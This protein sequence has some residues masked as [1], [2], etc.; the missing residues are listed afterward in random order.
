MYDPMETWASKKIL[1]ELLGELGPTPKFGP[2][3]GWAVHFTINENFV[4]ATGRDFLGSRDIDVFLDCRGNFPLQ[5]ARAI[6]KI[7]F[8]PGEY[9]FRY[10]LILERDSMRK[11]S[12][13]EAGRKHSFELIYVF[14]DV[15]GNGESDAVGVW[16]NEIVAKMIKRKA[17]RPMT[18][19]GLKVFVPEEDFLLLL[20]LDSFLKRET[21]EKRMK[22]ACDIYGLLFYSSAK[23]LELLKKEAWKVELASRGIEGLLEEETSE[24]IAETL[25]GSGLKSG[26]V[27]RNIRQILDALS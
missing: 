20:K 26:L 12:E 21:K 25:F 13:D 1:L 17:T 9:R 4:R 5:F 2:V 22:D 15:L 10:T 6:R 8:I 23:I 14:L 24:F 19:E 27:R 3:G 11:L 7:G 16:P 18:I